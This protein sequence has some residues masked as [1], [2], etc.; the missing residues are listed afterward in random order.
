[1]YL[2]CS[3]Y[4][5]LIRIHSMLAILAHDAAKQ[6][7]YAL[8]AHYFIMKMWEQSFAAMNAIQFMETHIPE[9]SELG[10]T[11]TDQVSRRDYFT[12][13]FTGLDM[14]IP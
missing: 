9:L 11:M 13:I 5:K 6:K 7:E 3:H 8:D 2:N 14:Q 1:M 4:D 12:E 10:F